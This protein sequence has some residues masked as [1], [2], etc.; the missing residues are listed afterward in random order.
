MVS[1]YVCGACGFSEEWIDAPED[2]AKLKECTALNPPKALQGGYAAG[3]PPLLI[4]GASGGLSAARERTSSDF[5]FRAF[6]Q[7]QRAEGVR[8]AL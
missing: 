3:W 6:D 8:R 5:W 1:R 7:C 2:I 4:I